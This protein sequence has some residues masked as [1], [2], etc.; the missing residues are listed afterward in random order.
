MNHMY[1]E[2]LGRLLVALFVFVLLVLLVFPA[3][4]SFL[5]KI[6]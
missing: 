4:L 2:V 5:S 1:A 6:G 3:L